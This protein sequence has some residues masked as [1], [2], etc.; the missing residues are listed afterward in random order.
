MTGDEIDA[1]FWAQY[2]LFNSTTTDSSTT[3]PS[4]PI[5]PL[6]GSETPSEI[7]ENVTT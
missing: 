1:E 4:V 5:D 6:I 3:R 7:A 2:D